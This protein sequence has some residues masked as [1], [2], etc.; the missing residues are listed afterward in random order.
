MWEAK[1]TLLNMR[2]PD[3]RSVFAI[4]IAF[5]MT[6]TPVQAGTVVISD[7]TQVIG[8]LK[9]P[10][11]LRLNSAGR[12]SS[13][14]GAERSFE[15]TTVLGVRSIEILETS[16]STVANGPGSLLAGLKTIPD[17]QQQLTTQQIGSGTV[18]GT[19]CDC[20][21]ILIAGGAFP[22]WP[23]LFLA[24]IPLFFI[25]HGDDI[26]TPVSTPTPTPT[27]S[28]PTPTPEPA[29]LLLLGTGLAAFGFGLRRRKAK[30][31]VTKNPTN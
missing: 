7:V 24:T 3:L 31:L 15:S 8:N 5:L 13:V 18:Q 14:T 30:T 28:Q 21:E 9:N 16:N 11:E 17:G 26:Q 6:S 29:S 27:P 2:K 20:G 1:R 22:K 23:L 10:P 25:D 19:L 12:L 4:L